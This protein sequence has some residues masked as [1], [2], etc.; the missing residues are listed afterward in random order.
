[1]NVFQIVAVLLRMTSGVAEAPAIQRDCK[2]ALLMP[3]LVA[4]H[5]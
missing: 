3:G 2:M 1:M 4:S 5:P